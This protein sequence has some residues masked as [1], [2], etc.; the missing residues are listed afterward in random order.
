M[1]KL[2]GLSTEEIGS[3]APGIE[4]FRAYSVLIKV[5]EKASKENHS[6]AQLADDIK[7]LGERNN[8]V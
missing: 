6:K 2:T 8:F 3:I 7:E 4:G 5:V 1:N